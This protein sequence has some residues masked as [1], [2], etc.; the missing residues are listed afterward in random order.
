MILVTGGTGFVGQHVVRELLALG[1]KVRLL[2]RHPARAGRFQYHPQ[3][4]LVTGDVL[5]PE[6]LTAALSGVK[7]VIHL[8]G[9]IAETSRVTFEQAHLEATR[10]VL[11]AAQK[12]RV[13]RWI[14]MSAA[15]TR[16]E[17]RSR[18]HITKWQ[19]E[20][21]VRRSGLDWTIFRPSLI[22]GD[23]QDDRLLKTFRL[24]L[25]WPLGA[26]QLHTFPLLN[27]GRALI[28]PV[29]VHDVAHCFAHAVAKEP[30]IAKTYEL[31]GPVAFSWREMIFKIA[32][33]LGQKAVFDDFPLRVISRGLLWLLALLA[34]ILI[35]LSWHYGCLHLLGLEIAVGL[36]I[37][38]VLGISRWTELVVF[39]LPS[40]PLRTL[41][42]AWNSVAPRAFQFSEQLKMAEED[43]VGDPLPAMQAFGYTPESFDQGIARVLG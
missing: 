23:R 15:G 26:L 29:S 30:A 8:V 9:I 27:G 5:K 21:L 43:N 13:T 32:A 25:S 17:A 41:A 20:E 37:A 36:W 2:V 40:A 11:T 38:Y 10:N 16:A 22:Y 33:F 19:A 42:Q 7:V 31:V 28:Q 35:A 34:P 12:A 18:Y 1:Y 39:S 3:V 6:S 4:E 14:Q 24:L